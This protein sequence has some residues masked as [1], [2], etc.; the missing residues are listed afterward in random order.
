MSIQIK[1]EPG[2]SSSGSGVSCG[3]VEIKKEPGTSTQNSAVNARAALISKVKMNLMQAWRERWTEIQWAIQ[4]KKL[5]AAYSTENVD[6]A[7]ILMQQALVG[8]SPNSLILSYLKH[9]VLSLMIPYHTVLK[10]I[11]EFEDFSRPYCVLA[12]LHLAEMFGS[13]ISLS[14]CQDSPLQLVRTILSLIHWQVKALYTCLQRIQENR[15]G[16]VA[17][18]YFVIMDNASR[19]IINILERKAIRSLMQIAK[20]DSPDAYREFEQCEMNVGGTISQLPRTALL[21]ET[22]EKINSALLQLSKLNDVPP[23]P[24]SVLEIVN[25]PICPTINC[26]VVL[27]AILNSSSDIQPFVDQILV[28]SRLMKLPT[29]QLCLEIFRACFMGFVDTNDFAEDLQWA[30]F[31]FLKVPHILNAMKEKMPDWDMSSHIE[32]GLDMLLE[33]S[34]LLDQTDIKQKPE[35]LFVSGS[36]DMLVQFITELQKAN[37]I[38]DI[39]KTSLCMKRAEQRSRL[40]PSDISGTNDGKNLSRVTHAEATVTSILKSLDSDPQR[41]SESMI[42]VLTIMLQG[43]SFDILRLAAASTGRLNDFMSKLIRI[44]ELASQTTSESLKI[45]NKSQLFDVTFLMIISIVQQNGLGI[46]LSSRENEYALVI[47]WAKRWLPEEGKYKNVEFVEEQ[48]KVDSILNLMLS[49]AEIVPCGQISSWKEMI[50]Y[51]PYA[52]QE[53][54]FAYEHM[55]LS[56]EKVKMIIDHIRKQNIKSLILVCTTY[57]CSYMNMVGAAA[58]VKPL[59]MLEFFTS[60]LGIETKQPIQAIIDNIIYDIL[61]EG[62]LQRPIR[63]YQLSSKK[64]TSEIMNETLKDSFHRGWLNM[65]SLHTLEQ[66]LALRGPDWFCSEMV[67]HLL[68]QNHT[69]DATQSLSLAF[70]IMHMDL[71]CMTISLLRRVLPSLL[72]TPQNSLLTDPRGHCLAKLCVLSITATHMSKFGQKEPY[73]RRRHKRLLTDTDMDDVSDYF[74]SSEM[75][76][77]LFIC[78]FQNIRRH[79]EEVNFRPVLHPIRYSDTA[80]VYLNS[81]KKRFVSRTFYEARIRPRSFSATTFTFPK[82]AD[83]CYVSY[84]D[85]HNHEDRKW[86]KTSIEVK[87]RKFTAEHVL[88]PP[89]SNRSDFITTVT[90]S[91]THLRNSDLN[92]NYSPLED[93]SYRASSDLFAD[94]ITVKDKYDPGAS[95][96]YI[97]KPSQRS[98]NEQSLFAGDLKINF[99]NKNLDFNMNDPLLD[100]SDV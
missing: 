49:N 11:T 46:A 83:H 16:S 19:A 89:G 40:R 82:T 60:S 35:I 37:I 18:E 99:G 87:A 79:K 44:N 67:E 38:S 62:H 47:Q 14:P 5:M 39:Q 90:K 86:F 56:V 84:L 85:I 64:L 65:A 8:S 13:K 7:E 3:M 27:E 98:I 77:V 42:K 58:R 4:L 74:P 100:F 97:P 54:L 31:A 69:D 20:T 92:S 1:K 9:G 51:L 21:D 36:F 48:D 80:Y 75:N 28:V 22:R 59:K 63:R 57:L 34:H 29:P 71:E 12:L 50:M 41:N 91:S 15:Q 26:L 43:H 73:V 70:A 17:P 81:T 68:K 72:T 23:A 53:I 24:E 52:L 76:I 94:G 93:G 88:R 32:K 10:Y 96:I 95:Q 25:S 78:I 30:T 55:A 2:S 33:L 45:P 66:L 6:V 61:P